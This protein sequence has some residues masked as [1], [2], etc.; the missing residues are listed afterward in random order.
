MSFEHEYTWYCIDCGQEC[1]TV[2]E[3]FDYAGTHCTN[4]RPG[5][6]QTGHYVS[7]CCGAEFS[8]EPQDDPYA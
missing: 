7:A 8:D 3:T 4:G 1:E 5:T 6:H 2:E